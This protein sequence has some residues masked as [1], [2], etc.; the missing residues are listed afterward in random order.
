MRIELWTHSKISI[1][2]G[3]T[4]LWNKAGILPS[5]V[6]ELQQLASSVN[7]N[8]IVWRGDPLWQTSAQGVKILGTPIGH[9]AFVKAQLMARR[10]DHDVLL[11]THP[12]RSRSASSFG[13]YCHTAPLPGPTSHCAQC[14]LIWWEPLRVA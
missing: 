14:D 11:V 1:H 9:E 12:C 3:K 13:C 6:E 4:K 10:A 2:H 5:G 7:E 8:A